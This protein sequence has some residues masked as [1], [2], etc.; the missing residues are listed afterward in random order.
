VKSKP[1]MVTGEEGEKIIA[2]LKT[3]KPEIK[4]FIADYM[5]KMRNK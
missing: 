3:V 2:Q 1:I 5:K 4:T